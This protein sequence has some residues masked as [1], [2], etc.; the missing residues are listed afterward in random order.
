M[1]ANSLPAR[2]AAQTVLDE[3]NAAHGTHFQLDRLFDGGFQSGAWHLSDP[4]TPDGRAVLKW[5][6]DLSWAS[7]IE[8][9]AAA[10]AKIRAAGYPTPAWLAVGTT[11]SGFGYQIQDFVPGRRPDLVT[12]RE[13]HLLIDVLETHADLNPDPERCWS[14]YVDSMADEREKI[15]RR[16]ELIGPTEQRLV[17]ACGR[18][19]AAAGSVT[20]PTTDLVHGD[21]R[22]GNILLDANGTNSENDAQRVAGI[23]DIEALGNGTRVFDYATLL[24]AHGITPEATLLLCT[25][26]EQVAGPEALAYCFAH[27]ALDLAAFVHDRNLAPG[28]Q[29]IGKLTERA[30]FLLEPRG[31]VLSDGNQPRTA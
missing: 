29:N 10:V 17:A 13:A 16:L 19:L 2:A 22:P 14:E 15:S 26:A 23:I 24:S 28:I 9:A 6:P 21:F 8:R 30:E 4:T 31:P 27:V 11:T 12:I 18:L 20:L 5:S 3:A 25:A 1:P 7:Q